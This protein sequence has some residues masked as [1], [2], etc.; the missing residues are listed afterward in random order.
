MT[1]SGTTYTAAIP[2]GTNTAGANVSYYVFTSGPSNVAADGSN[3]DLYTINLN[4]N[5]G[6]NYSYIINVSSASDIV[7]NTSYSST[8]PDFN[9]NPSYIN[10]TD[11]TATTAGKI[12][13]MKFQIRDGGAANDIDNLPTILTS[14]TFN[15]TNTANA[16]RGNELKHH[17]G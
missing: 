7:D 15:V 11:A 1:G 2:A 5:A 10:F 6:A 9:I 17:R 3:A 12:I 14:L 8:A 13:A 4:N 16:I